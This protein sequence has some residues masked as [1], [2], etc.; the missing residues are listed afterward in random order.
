[1][2][3]NASS[4]GVSEEAAE[5]VEFRADD[6]ADVMNKL[7]LSKQITTS[8]RGNKAG[9][10]N[11]NKTAGNNHHNVKTFNGSERLRLTKFV[12]RDKANGN[13]QTGNTNDQTSNDQHKWKPTEAV[14]IHRLRA[15]KR[16]PLHGA[17]L[18][19]GKFPKV[20]DNTFNRWVIDRR[21]EEIRRNE[22]LLK[23]TA[24]LLK[25]NAAN[26]EK[27]L[28]A[29][30]AAAGKFPPEESGRSEGEEDE[31]R[32][33]LA[34]KKD[35]LGM[36]QN[37][38]KS[39]RSAKPLFKTT[40][41]NHFS[42][43]VSKKVTKRPQKSPQKRSPKG[44]QKALPKRAQKVVR[45]SHKKVGP[46]GC[47]P[48]LRAAVQPAAPEGGH[49]HFSALWFDRKLSLWVFAFGSF[50]WM[51][52]GISHHHFKSHDWRNIQTGSGLSPLSLQ[53]RRIL[54]LGASTPSLSGNS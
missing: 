17:N 29:Q 5:G 37:G 8:R 14:V 53:G 36:A 31:R 54:A 40:F 32:V 33:F 27:A 51:S 21:D 46:K 45:K 26:K 25:E 7:S 16:P 3:G 4:R 11:L 2:H 28:A 34:C 52:W 47:R 41:Q 10:W 39:G 35:H 44:P 24:R 20:S 22:E 13:D 30:E 19:H 38:S 15:Y 49:S 1:L 48:V 12:R 18:P 6:G 23:E 43:K 50:P 9:F 42:K